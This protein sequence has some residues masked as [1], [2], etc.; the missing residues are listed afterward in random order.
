VSETIAP[1]GASLVEAVRICHTAEFQ[2]L[3]A[4]DARR[5]P[6]LA[7]PREEGV[8]STQRADPDT[9]A[10]SGTALT[11]TDAGGYACVDPEGRGGY[12]GA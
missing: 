12:R 2:G 3:T 4:G 7:S 8:R 10:E 1:E 9:R 5:P 6:S 11:G